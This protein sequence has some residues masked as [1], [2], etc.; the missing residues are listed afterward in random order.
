MERAASAERM[1]ACLLQDL[2]RP[3]FL[4]WT[5]TNL[6]WDNA[7]GQLCMDP[8]CVLSSNLAYRAL[9]WPV[10]ASALASWVAEA[11][12]SKAEPWVSVGVEF[13]R[14]LAPPRVSVAGQPTSSR[15][16]AALTA[17]LPDQPGSEEGIAASGSASHAHGPA[18]GH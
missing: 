1:Y 7:L 5:E 9:V 15:S 18:T 3:A 6:R 13:V 4:S 17:R 14:W 12:R 8:L 11:R 10:V 16:T 2:S